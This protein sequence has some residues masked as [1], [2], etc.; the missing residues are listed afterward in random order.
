M[1]A[2][3]SFFHVADAPCVTSAESWIVPSPSQIA[4]LSAER[5][6]SGFGLIVTVALVVG[7]VAASQYLSLNAEIEYVTDEP[8]AV[9]KVGE[10]VFPLASVCCD[11]VVPSE[12]VN[13]NVFSP[14]NVN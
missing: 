8:G 10:N 6:T 1:N 2:V 12:Y 9:G 13:E 7:N 3:P 11:D 5:F 4:S 14:V